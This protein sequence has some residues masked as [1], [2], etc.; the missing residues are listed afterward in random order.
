MSGLSGR[1]VA[2]RN[3]CGLS[4]FLAPKIHQSSV[5]KFSFYFTERAASPSQRSVGGSLS[6]TQHL[7]TATAMLPNP[8][9]IKQKYFSVHTH[10]ISDRALISG[11]YPSF[12]HLSFWKE[13]ICRW[14]WI[15][16]TD[17]M[18][19]TRE[20]RSTRR[21]TCPSANSSTTNITLWGR[22]RWWSSR[23]VGWAMAQPWRIKLIQII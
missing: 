12:A 15:W 18:I 11:R 8:L 9:T 16:R 7:F 17:G 22:I 10:P 14:R 2:S 21:E 5:Q 4:V 23:V 6:G 13:Q 19:T 3:K 20:N 1:L